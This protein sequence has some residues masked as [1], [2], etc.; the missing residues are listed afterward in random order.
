MSTP[1]GNLK[2]NFGRNDIADHSST[3]QQSV[4][5]TNADNKHNSAVSTPIESHVP[6]ESEA[7]NQPQDPIIQIKLEPGSTIQPEPAASAPPGRIQP[8]DSPPVEI[9]VEPESPLHTHMEPVACSQNFYS[10]VHETDTRLRSPIEDNHFKFVYPT[11]DPNVPSSTTGMEHASYQL[12]HPPNSQMELPSLNQPGHTP[13]ELPSFPRLA[14]STFMFARVGF[15]PLGLLP[16]SPL[17][18][19]GPFSHLQPDVVSRFNP[20][21]VPY[22]GFPFTTQSEFN[23]SS[24]N[25]PPVQN[26][27]EPVACTP[28]ACT[29][30]AYTPVTYTPVAYT[31]V[32][33]TPVACT[34]VACTPVAYTPVEYK[35]VA[36]TPVT[37]TPVTYTPVACT[38][39]PQIHGPQALGQVNFIPA[40]HGPPQPVLHSGYE[41]P[42]EPDPS[43]HF[44]P[45]QAAH[46]EP[47]PATHS[48]SVQAAH[49]EPE[50][51]THSEPD[52]A[53]YSEPRP[54]APHTIDAEIDSMSGLFSSGVLN[55]FGTAA[56]TPSRSPFDFPA[57][58]RSIKKKVPSGR[59]TSLTDMAS[60]MQ[61]NNP[62]T[63]TVKQVAEAPLNLTD[64]LSAELSSK[65]YVEIVTDKIYAESA[66]GDIDAKSAAEKVTGH[67][68]A[69]S[70]AI[71]QVT[72]IPAKNPMYNL[73]QSSGEAPTVVPTVVPTVAPTIAPT[74][75]PTEAPTEAPTIAPTIAPTEV[76]TEAPT[77][78]KPAFKKKAFK[79]TE[80]GESSNSAIIRRSKR[81]ANKQA[82]LKAVAEVGKR[83]AAAKSIRLVE[84]PT[85]TSD[86]SKK[87]AFGKDVSVGHSRRDANDEY[88]PHEDGQPAFKTL[89]GGRKKRAAT[90]SVTYKDRDLDEIEEDAL[91]KKREKKLTPKAKEALASSLKPAKA[92]VTRA[93][94][95]SGKNKEVEKNSP[96][97]AINIDTDNKVKGTKIAKIETC[98]PVQTQKSSEIQTNYEQHCGNRFTKFNQEKRKREETD[99]GRP[100]VKKSKGKGKASNTRRGRPP[101]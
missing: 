58:T 75:A 87:Q 86:H 26:V 37:Y 85:Q 29:P 36:C 78:S 35:P 1:T 22:F 54:S 52:P 71:K 20:A 17:I 23:A 53:A 97:K 101:K 72:G 12:E 11:L 89:T 68:T 90:T 62:L 6:Y 66:A 47:D 31:P 38:E 46:S 9:K 8:L 32:T 49:S 57:H 88:V 43:T 64:G 67:P 27:L 83:K 77:T 15:P 39:P 5:T 65:K 100:K 92:V 24:Q 2:V 7:F 40:L 59:A 18:K 30:V 80:S 33:Y 45:D 44:E 99:V 93:K 79:A 51:A 61:G 28:V 81:L 41:P 74:I 10:P 55:V 94:R 96:M 63:E 50:P 4:A 98:K 3:D 76:P 82:F 60:S 95:S 73:G 48:E 25:E 56:P 21:L 70:L 13:P 19:P 16:R 91:R 84:E 69:E 42:T 14:S 34:P